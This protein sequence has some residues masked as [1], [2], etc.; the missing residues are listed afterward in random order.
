[1]VETK[2]KM[3]LAEFERD[4]EVPAGAI[5]VAVSPVGPHSIRDKIYFLVPIAND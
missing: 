4:D 3:R 1:M 5:F 2:Q